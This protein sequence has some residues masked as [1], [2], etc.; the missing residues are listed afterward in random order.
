MSTKKKISV[1]VYID[2][3]NIYHAIEAIKKQDIKWVNYR[4]L[5]ES[6]LR[7]SE[8]LNKVYFFTSITTWGIE[9]KERHETFIRALKAMNV[10][11]IEARFKKN[12]RY[13]RTFDR[14][15]KFW[16]EKENDVAI[17]V[18]M[19]ADAHAGAARRLIL[20]TAD[21]D[22]IPSIKYLRK[23]FPQTELSLAIPPGRRGEARKLTELFNKGR[24]SVEIL[25]GRLRACL[26]PTKIKP[27][28]G[29]EI[30]MPAEYA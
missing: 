23:T 27:A 7:Q 10:D 16:E 11:V 28:K 14:R 4:K 30:R 19:I 2:G 29:P 12:R 9:K 21:T 3:F 13:C 26:L 18:Q 17:A 8:Y 5:S 1:N 20:I 22:Q 24:G 25:E 6:F 15:C